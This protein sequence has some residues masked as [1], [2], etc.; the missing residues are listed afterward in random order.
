MQ[1]EEYRQLRTYTR[2]DGLYLAILWSASF[3]CTVMSSLGTIVGAIGNL[4][5]LASPFFVG[6]W[7][8]RYRDDA[9]GGRISFRRALLF[10]F[11]VFFDGAFIFAICQFLY[12]K[13]LDNGKLL[14]V[15]QTMM[16]MPEM[17]PVIQAYGVSEAELN[18]AMQQMFD[19]FA[20][21]SYSFI[22]AC[23]CG[24]VLSFIIAA[25]MKKQ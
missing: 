16:S 24:A 5:A 2:Y 23:I 3:A 20:L 14:H 25:I 13:F 11:Q 6:Y 8:K 9:L 4:L 21:A 7:V 17:K 19:P 1:S 18:Q 12:M 22:V 15:Y 10:C